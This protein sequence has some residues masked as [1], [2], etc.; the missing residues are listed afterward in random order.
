MICNTTAYPV[1]IISWLRDSTLL[2]SDNKTT[3]S[4]NAVLEESE[5]FFV[6]SY[7]LIRG[8]VLN[9]TTNYSCVSENDLV[10]QQIVHS[11]ELQLDVLCKISIYYCTL[12]F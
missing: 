6:S 1:P 7:L 3:I 10:S 11:E 8:L 9:D 2:A 12:M 5:L 4:S